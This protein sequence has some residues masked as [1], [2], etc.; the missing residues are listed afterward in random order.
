MSPY[1]A[2]LS[3]R[4]RMMLQYRTAALAGAGTQVAEAGAGARGPY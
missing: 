1:L 4:Y 3:A 2:I